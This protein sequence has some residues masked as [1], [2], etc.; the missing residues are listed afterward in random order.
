MRL[1]WLQ[2]EGSPFYLYSQARIT[3]NFR[4]YE[5]A[6]DGLDSIIGYA[7]KANNNMPIARHLAGLG[8]GAVLVSGNELRLALAAGFDPTRCA[9]LQMGSHQRRTVDSTKRITMSA[10]V[11]LLHAMLQVPIASAKQALGFALAQPGHPVRRTIFNGNGKLPAELR[12]AVEQGVLINCDSE[13]DLDNIAEAARAVG[14]AARVLIRINPDIDP[15]VHAYVSTGLANSKFG[16]RNSHL[17][18]S[19]QTPLSSL[20]PP[21]TCIFQGVGV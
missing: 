12:F 13:F 2:V 9:A 15:Q 21:D 16:I 5:E 10:H 3:A 4:A 1:C 6:L 17:Q 11:V 14:K 18:V 8:S 7:I 19:S 20:I